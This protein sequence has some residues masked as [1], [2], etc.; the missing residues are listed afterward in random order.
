M[1]GR[2]KIKIPR[3]SSILGEH[4][5]IKGELHFAGGLHLDGQVLG[6]VIAEPDSNATLVVSKTG[7]VEGNV[8]V[9]N[10]ILDGTIAGDVE[11]DG[12]V[13]LMEGAKVTGTVQYRLLEMA[14]G[15]A[16]NGKLMHVDE[17]QAPRR[18][19]HGIPSEQDEIT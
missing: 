8:R 9:V 18:L 13:Q 14:A 12:K 17:G 2:K 4:S 7:V 3:I 19:E 15:A 16:V 10:L 1:L 11:A 6:N 5:L